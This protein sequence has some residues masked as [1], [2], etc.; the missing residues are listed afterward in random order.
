MLNVDAL[1]H[2][3]NEV[4]IEIFQ[5]TRLRN[6]YGILNQAHFAVS[7]MDKF[8]KGFVVLGEDEYLEELAWLISLSLF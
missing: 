3:R 7:N 6:A 4:L 5:L 1:T 8:F 2:L